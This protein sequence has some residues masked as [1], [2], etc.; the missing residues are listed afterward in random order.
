MQIQWKDQS[1]HS[2]SD[3]AKVPNNWVANVG[4]LRVVIHRHVHYSEDTW[5]LTC[6]PFFDKKPLKNVL[7]G[8]AKEEAIEMIRSELA[9][10][11]GVISVQSDSKPKA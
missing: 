2:R 7:I 1:T 10:A 5:L 11:M 8:D 4:R 9:A 3:T 6:A